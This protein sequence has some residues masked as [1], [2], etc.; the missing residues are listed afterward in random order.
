MRMTADAADEIKD[1]ISVQTGYPVDSIRLFG[2]RVYGTP[3]DDSDLDVAILDA[4]R[5]NDPMV[6]VP[7]QSGIIAE[8]RFVDNL[9]I[10]WLRMSL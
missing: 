8:I 5:I 1:E 2:S 7:L 3:R 6:R 9:K 10:S 4:Q